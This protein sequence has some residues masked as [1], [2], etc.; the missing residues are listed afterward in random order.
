M[1]QYI[2]IISLLLI[3]LSVQSQELKMADFRAVYAKVKG[4][5]RYGYVTKMTGIFPNGK[6]DQTETIS[7]IDMDKS[8]LAYKSDIEQVILTPKWFYKAS[9]QEEYVSIF[10]VNKYRQKYPGAAGDLSAAFKS[11]VAIDYIDSAVSRY[12]KLKSG[13]KQGNLYVFEF[14]FPQD[15]Y[16]KSLVFKFDT[17][18]GLPHSM[19]MR[20]G[21]EDDYG[22]KMDMSILC[23][24]YTRTFSDDVFNTAPYFSVSGSK[25]VLLKYK[26]YKLTTIL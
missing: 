6:S 23:D 20:M 22:R 11:T 3:S 13:R 9:F 19:A 25:A 8:F 17:Q 16:L 18:S 2:A 14:S 12:G 10:E 21:T 26:K 4:L 5:K 1:K 24:G 7:Y 15:S